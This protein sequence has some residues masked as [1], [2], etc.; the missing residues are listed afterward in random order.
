MLIGIILAVIA[1]ICWGSGGVIF[2]L[3]LRD[4][5][6]FSG[7]FLRSIFAS[8][9]LLPIVIIYGIEKITP[10]LLL[11]L[12]LSTF[13][14]F[15]VGDLFYFN[16]LKNSSVSYVLPLASTYPIFVAIMDNF[17]YRAEIKLNVIL[18]CLTTLMAIIVI[19][20]ETG[21]FSVKSF[22]AIFASLSWAISIVTLDY[23]TIY[24][25]PVNLTFL[26]LL[27]NSAML[28]AITRTLDFDRRTVV[29]MGI[30]GGIV[31]VTGILSFVTAVK[32][33][34]SHLVSPISATSPV[35]GVIIGNLILKER[36]YLRHVIAMFLVFLSVTL[37]SLF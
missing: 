28:F 7:N 9:Y 36:I 8:M 29:Y 33:M 30:L 13:F 12:L 6:E 14:S 1:A 37:I 21:K 4:V 27:I 16:A 3:G 17:V 20:K 35:I 31:S 22:F 5:N 26:R 15:F 24:I 23:L 34:G 25:S 2:K 11:I 18:A 10:M 32:I 19:P